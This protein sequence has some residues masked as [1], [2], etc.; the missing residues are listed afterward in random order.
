MGKLREVV[1][2]VVVLGGVVLGAHTAS[3]GSCMDNPSTV[4][5]CRPVAECQQPDALGVAHILCGPE[6]VA[7][8]QAA[9]CP[10]LSPAL[11]TALATQLAPQSA[12]VGDGRIKKSDDREST[13]FIAGRLEHGSVGLW[14]TNDAEEPQ[15]FFSVNAAARMFSTWPPAPA[16]LSTTTAGAADALE[17]VT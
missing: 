1:L 9:K 2:G 7:T 17:C 15:A 14:T 16:S 12:L 5:S 4:Q 8:Y 10:P 3:D 13:Y 11:A 6:A